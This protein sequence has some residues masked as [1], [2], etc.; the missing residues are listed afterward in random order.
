[1]CEAVVHLTSTWSAHYGFPYYITVGHLWWKKRVP[2]GWEDR[3]AVKTDEK[4]AVH[5]D[6]YTL[7]HIGIEGSET[8]RFCPKCLVKITTTINNTK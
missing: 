7:V 2:N 5:K 4:I 6:C 3:G 8:F 1:M